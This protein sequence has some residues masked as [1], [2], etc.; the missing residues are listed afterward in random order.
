MPGGTTVVDVPLM[1]VQHFLCTPRHLTRSLLLFPVLK[2]DKRLEK[3]ARPRCRHSIMENI[4][5][6]PTPIIYSIILSLAIDAPRLAVLVSLKC[7]LSV[8]LVKS[9]CGSS[10][11]CPLICRS[12]S[13]LER[14]WLRRSVL[15]LQFLQHILRAIVGPLAF[16]NIETDCAPCTARIGLPTFHRAICRR[17]ADIFRVPG[18]QREDNCS[19]L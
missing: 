12:W 9:L 10:S 7:S 19:R 18:Q 14:D 1:V 11:P 17:T 5:C 15:S 3:G 16:R 4:Q 2:H 8:L 13:Q 6:A